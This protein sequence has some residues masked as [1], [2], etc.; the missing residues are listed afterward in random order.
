MIKPT[1]DGRYRVLSHDGSR[2]FGTY[3]TEVQAEQRLEQIE[4]FAESKQTSSKEIR[5]RKAKR[6]PLHEDYASNP[7]VPL[8]DRIYNI[9]L[10]LQKKYPD[11]RVPVG[12][13]RGFTTDATRKEFDFAIL[14]LE[15][16]N[17]IKLIV[18]DSKSR[19]LG[20]YIPGRGLLFYA[21][22]APLEA[23]EEEEE[24]EEEKEA[25]PWP[26]PRIDSPRPEAVGRGLVSSLEPLPA[27]TALAIAP[28]A[29]PI[30]APLEPL[31]LPKTSP[32]QTTALA[33]PSP[34]RVDNHPVAVY[35]ARLA[36][37]S[38]RSAS[39]ALE[40]VAKILHSDFWSFP[41]KDIRYQH[42]Q[43][44]RTKLSEK[45]KFNTANK[46]LSYTRGVLHECFRL[47]LMTA[48]EYLRA[49]D[50]PPVQGKKVISG[51]MI[52]PEEM[53]ELFSVIQTSNIH[54][55]RNVAILGLLAGGGLRRSEI[56]S[57]DYDNLINKNSLLVTGKGNKER[58]VVLGPEI[59]LA[60]DAWI[61]VRGTEPGPLFLPITKYD[62]IV[63]RRLTDQTVYYIL[64]ETIK[65]TG[66]KNLSP[67]DFRRTYISTLFDNGI[68]IVTVQKMVGH[69]SPVTTARY[70]RRGL[71]AQQKAADS[72]HIP[73]EG[74]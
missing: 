23:L 40:I 32:A 21:S 50:I 54:N 41:W 30:P 62:K 70:D 17:K 55:T 2:S 10:R 47:G 26:L 38:R 19:D 45:Y 29:P 64:E 20:I 18:D 73:T 68:D 37:G 66:I 72:L 12:A 67:H 74:L 53:G 57:L 58:I 69:S 27:S 63:N 36:P 31:E 71:E 15:N 46:I 43:A 14:G 8:G 60:L 59:V 48:D 61:K 4:T 44:I 39:E 13:I 51:R 33:L 9:L 34:A 24:F 35:L 16:K 56:V 22:E 1:S 5:K 11:G 49:K 6:N 28:R 7:N 42:M 3:D 25:S 52:P 65:K